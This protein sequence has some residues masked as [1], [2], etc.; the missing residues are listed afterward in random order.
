MPSY[1]ESGKTGNHP[2]NFENNYVK[3]L[4]KRQE[5]HIFETKKKIKISSPL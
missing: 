3:H 1:M 2:Q 5:K 4:H